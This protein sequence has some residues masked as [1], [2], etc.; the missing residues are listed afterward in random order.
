MRLLRLHADRVRFGLPALVKLPSIPRHPGPTLNQLIDPR[1]PQIQ[2]RRGN[3]GHTAGHDVRAR[4][5]RAD[6][7]WKCQAIR[8]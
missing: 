3:H 2:L 4:S 7:G 1:G 8:R 6:Q 5:Q